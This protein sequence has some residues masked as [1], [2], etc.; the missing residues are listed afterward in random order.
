MAHRVAHCD[1]HLIN[2]IFVVTG[3]VLEVQYWIHVIHGVVHR[4]TGFLVLLPL[5]HY[6]LHM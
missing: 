3:V 5:R 6:Q 4:C 2:N 1:T